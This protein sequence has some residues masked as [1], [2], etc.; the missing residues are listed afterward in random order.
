MSKVRDK[1]IGSEL[2]GLAMFVL[3][4]IEEERNSKNDTN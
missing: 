4:T 1:F 2:Y 3:I